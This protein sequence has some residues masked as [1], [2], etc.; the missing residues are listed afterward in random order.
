MTGETFSGN[1]PNQ[2]TNGPAD[3]DPSTTSLGNEALSS[4]NALTDENLETLAALIG[5]ELSVPIPA[6]QEMRTHSHQQRKTQELMKTQNIIASK[7]IEDM[8]RRKEEQEETEDPSKAEGFSKVYEYLKN[9][10]SSNPG[11]IVNNCL[12]VAA[13]FAAASTENGSSDIIS[14]IEN[15]GDFDPTGDKTQLGKLYRLLAQS[16]NNAVATKTKGNLNPLE[17]SPFNE[18]A[19]WLGQL[20]PLT[21]TEEKRDGEQALKPLMEIIIRHLSS[22]DLEDQ[23]DNFRN[24]Q[25]KSIT[26]RL[27]RLTSSVEDWIKERLPTEKIRDSMHQRITE[28]F[29]NAIEKLGFREPQTTEDVFDLIERRAEL[30]RTINNNH[31]TRLGLTKIRNSLANLRKARGITYSA[32]RPDRELIRKGLESIT[33]LFPRLAT[34][35]A[36]LLSPQRLLASDSPAVISII[37]GITRK[38]GP[39]TSTVVTKSL[40]AALYHVNRYYNP[41]NKPNDTIEQ[42][43]QE[44]VEVGG[45]PEIAKPNGF[46]E[47]PALTQRIYQTWLTPETGLDVTDD[48]ITASRAKVINRIFKTEELRTDTEFT[49]QV[50]DGVNRAIDAGS[51]HPVETGLQ[52]A[53]DAIHTAGE[54]LSI[55]EAAYLSQQLILYNSIAHKLKEKGNQDRILERKFELAVK[56]PMG[57][58][59]RRVI[60]LQEA[61]AAATCDPAVLSYLDESQQATL[62]ERMGQYPLSDLLELDEFKEDQTSARTRLEQFIANPREFIKPPDVPIPIDVSNSLY[63]N[64][65]DFEDEA[66]TISKL[67]TLAAIGIMDKDNFEAILETAKEQLIKAFADG[68]SQEL[69]LLH[70]VANYQAARRIQNEARSQTVTHQFN[71]GDIEIPPCTL[72]FL[73][74]DSA[75]KLQE[76]HE[77]IVQNFNKAQ[78]IVDSAANDT[79]DTEVA[80]LAARKSLNPAKLS[81]AMKELLEDPDQ[82]GMLLRYVGGK[83]NVSSIPSGL[84]FQKLENEEDYLRSL[85]QDFQVNEQSFNNLAEYGRYLA[86][87]ISVTTLESDDVDLND[88]N[89]INLLHL[90][91]Y[92]SIM[93]HVEDE[94]RSESGGG[95]GSPG[96]SRGA[97]TTT[98]ERA[99]ASGSSATS[100]G[101]VREHEERTDN[102]EIASPETTYQI[103]QIAPAMSLFNYQSPPYDSEYNWDET[104]FEL[105]KNGLMETL[106]STS[107]MAIEDMLSALSD[108]GSEENLQGWEMPLMTETTSTEVER[109]LTLLRTL[110]ILSMEQ[111]ERLEAAIIQEYGKVLARA[112]GPVLQTAKA[113][114]ESNFFSAFE[115]LD[116]AD[117][118]SIIRSLVNFSI[119]ANG[120]QAAK[121]E[122]SSQKTSEVPQIPDNLPNWITEVGD[123]F[124]WPQEIFQVLDS[125]LNNKRK[126][127][128]RATELLDEIGDDETA[129]IIQ[130]VLEMASQSEDTERISSPITDTITRI[131]TNG[132]TVQEIAAAF[133]EMTPEGGAAYQPDHKVLFSYL[134][135]LGREEPDYVID[136]KLSELSAKLAAAAVDP[137]NQASVFHLLAEYAAMRKLRED[138][139]YSFEALQPTQYLINKTIDRAAQLASDPDLIRKAKRLLPEDKVWSA[140]FNKNDEL[141]DPEQFRSQIREQITPQPPDDKEKG[142]WSPYDPHTIQIPHPAQ[143]PLCPTRTWQAL[144]YKIDTSIP[145]FYPVI[146]DPPD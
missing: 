136:V 119:I 41:E 67:M 121:I 50:E 98:S 79:G 63:A 82:L 74:E 59:A 2:E 15:P 17:N 134:R 88:D 52:D 94:S 60:P 56:P 127:L 126:A 9:F 97:D 55:I 115:N 71:P 106:E 95:T 137:D 76:R 25:D 36:E 129:S 12:V 132:P 28:L 66:G 96:G 54:N 4:L 62:A 40:F 99:D 58:S 72:E 68:N 32:W 114:D 8:K 125:N 51:D 35:H 91:V 140:F 65:D 110:N 23:L 14:Q 53:I 11:T 92:L 13:C 128:D 84:D 123:K 37:D 111:A 26:S 85:L 105:T 47:D 6:P 18:A 118:E 109:D 143:T 104:D 75:S 124:S 144:G 3:F 27:R 93:N 81:E 108:S 89:S 39:R 78:D 120:V 70:A 146:L 48:N 131:I 142:F 130:E 77:T 5:Q 45:D 64:L 20:Y 7:Q 44:L 139:Q 16:I 73:P 24:S 30:R 57:E 69:D 87:S 86:D 112:L 42:T 138:P 31:K 103:E 1:E 122:A 38:K 117:Q 102:E 34:N 116:P 101:R 29:E 141:R 61:Y 21:Y 133:T 33:E 80:R 100:S 107:S 19:T 43:L 145:D 22:S 49:R 46:P 83:I 10:Y 90:A 135:T 113:G